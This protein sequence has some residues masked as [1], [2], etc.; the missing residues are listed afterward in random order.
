MYVCALYAR[1]RRRLAI[2]STVARLYTARAAHNNDGG[3]GKYIYY[4]I[5]VS[6]VAVA[7]RASRQK[8]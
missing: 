4:F 7:V 5:I 2:A 8:V 3:G 6:S 1:L